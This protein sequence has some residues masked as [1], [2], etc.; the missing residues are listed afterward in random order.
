MIL[1]KLSIPAAVICLIISVA[2]ADATTSPD[3]PLRSRPSSLRRRALV[4]STESSRCPGEVDIPRK[5][6]L[7]S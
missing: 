5:T 3:S 1:R 7:S 4:P 6:F 2:S